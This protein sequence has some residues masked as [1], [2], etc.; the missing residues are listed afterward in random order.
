MEITSLKEN[1][2]C[3][4]DNRHEQRVK[5]EQTAVHSIGGLT[6][7]A[8]GETQI[9]HHQKTQPIQ[10]FCKYQIPY[11]TC[12]KIPADKR[13]FIKTYGTLSYG[14]TTYLVCPSVRHLLWCKWLAIQPR[15]R[16]VPC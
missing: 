5:L 10:E 4:P 6:N 3:R 1:K 8:Y 2:H 13:K 11:H 7:V 15:D 14:R 16:I 12:T 9:L